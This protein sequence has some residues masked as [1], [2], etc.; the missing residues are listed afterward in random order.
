[1]KEM[2]RQKVK[3]VAAEVRNIVVIHL[4]GVVDDPF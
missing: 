2:V 3:K 1:M 4:E